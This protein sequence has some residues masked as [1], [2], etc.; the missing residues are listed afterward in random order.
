MYIGNDL[1]R[2]RSETYYYTS[3]SGGETSITTD[4]SGKTI[5]Y[6]VGWV[7]VYL[8]G[9]RLHDSDFTA[10]TGNSIT[11]LAALSQDDV[12]II[13]AQHTFSSSDA[14]P[15]TGGT[16]SGNV[17]HSGTVTNNSTTT[18]TGDATHNGNIIMA[19]NKKI[20][21]KGE[22]YM[23]SSHQSWVLGG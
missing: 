6:T 18:T 5:N 22:A 9:V 3:T 16:F 23:H 20:K 2:G 1:S 4:S 14:V 10:T 19:T 7:A 21:Q 11:G 13:E 8:N 15:S 17:T 12:V